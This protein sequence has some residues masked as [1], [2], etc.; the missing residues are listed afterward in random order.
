MLL[1]FLGTNGWYDTPAGNTA[2][3]VLQTAREHIVLDAGNGVYKLDCFVLDRK[4]IYLFV[5]H[6]HC[7]HIYGLH[8][9]NKF[10]FPQGIQIYGPKG[11]KK[12]LGDL[13]RLPY[14]VPLNKLK[15]M[16][17]IH[18]IDAARTL[19]VAME[20]RQLKH[21]SPCYGYRF[22]IEGKAVAYCT[23][24][25][26]NKNIVLLG[27][28]TDLLVTECSFATGMDGAKAGHLTPEDAA[29][30]A[31]EA[32]AKRLILTHFDPVLYPDE[33]DRL[34]AVKAARRI[35]SNTIAAFDDMIVEV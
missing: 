3:L 32:N 35:F 28:D 7:D 34:K 20:F 8:I 23:D 1:S 22:S 6:Y 10:D 31:K 21:P 27:K 12:Y 26:L 15:T 30:A 19:P 16:V 5:S 13:L 17:G 4:P 11:A 25:A 18:D 29:G 33:E 9:L 2:C 14:T 24:T